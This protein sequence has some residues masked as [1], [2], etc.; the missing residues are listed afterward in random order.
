MMKRLFA[1]LAV[2]TAVVSAASCDKND[3][4]PIDNPAVGKSDTVDVNIRTNSNWSTWTY[5][6]FDNGVVA[7]T[8]DDKSLDSDWDIA[9]H[10][11]SVKTNGGSS[12]KGLGGAFLIDGAES[13]QSQLPSPNG[14]SYVEDTP[15]GV[16]TNFGPS[17]MQS[18]QMT[19]SGNSELS[20]W[21]TAVFGQGPPQHTFSPK[22][23]FVRT[24]DGRF[25]AIHF[26]DYTRIMPD[27]PATVLY[28]YPAF[29]FM[30]VD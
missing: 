12:G 29:E 7:V 16:T 14:L 8:A 30:F 20:K 9:F 3:T 1:I 2:V 10:L 21:L 5:Y 26:K 19:A 13:L 6:S 25:V 11:F 27:N 18:T 22:V 4:D 24:A 23:F 17:M 15:A 28:Y